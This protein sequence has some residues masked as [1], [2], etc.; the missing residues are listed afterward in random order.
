MAAPGKGNPPTDPHVG[1]CSACLHV[2]RVRSS[3]GST[4]YLCRR[5]E[6]DPRFD[7]YPRLPVVRCSGFQQADDQPSE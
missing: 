2:R 5:S 3:R 1:L 6:N 7:K 4:F